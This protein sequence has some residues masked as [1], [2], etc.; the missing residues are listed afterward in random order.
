[1][2]QTFRRRHSVLIVD[3]CDT[4][5]QFLQEMLSFIGFVEIH[6]CGDGWEALDWLEEHEGRVDLVISDW[7]MPEMT[8]LEL[9][10]K[11]R[12]TEQFARLPFLMITG[13]AEV[14][15][16]KEAMVAGADQYIVKPFSLK[17][18]QA[19]L[20]KVLGPEARTA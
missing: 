9:L 5:T 1:M 17:I 11:V 4:M 7:N 2:V 15:R 12:G 10:Q 6:V 8:G 13:E 14:E 3:D 16:I 18:L 19:K 20:D